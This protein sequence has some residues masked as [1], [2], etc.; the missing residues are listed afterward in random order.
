MNYLSKF[1][2]FSV[3]FMGANSASAF[4]YESRINQCISHAPR[5]SLL[6]SYQQMLQET[7]AEIQS[8][9]K[10]AIENI[11]QLARDGYFTQIETR[12]MIAEEEEMQK[13]SYIVNELYFS[14][15]L[16]IIDAASNQSICIYKI[17]LRSDAY[18][19]SD[20]MRRIISGSPKL[21]TDRIIQSHGED[22]FVQAVALKWW[23]DRTADNVCF[24]NY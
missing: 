22:R 18:D 7:R 24:F 13:Q 9:R 20:L 1:I 5:Q 3:V 19:N 4:D 12:E 16:E 11:Q 21:I 17:F 15:S 2:F 6:I 8:E 14:N 10:N 23:C